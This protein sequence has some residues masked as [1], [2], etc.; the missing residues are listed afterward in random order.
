MTGGVS[1][2]AVPQQVL[3]YEPVHFGWVRDRR[4]VARIAD[5]AVPSVR[6][7]LG[8]EAGYG[9]RWRW[10]TRAAQD[11]RRH[12]NACVGRQRRL[13]FNQT[14]EVMRNVDGQTAQ[15]APSCVGQ[16]FPA[17]RSAPVID[18]RLHAAGVVSADD[19]TID[20]LRDGTDFVE[21]MRISFLGIFRMWKA[22]LNER[23]RTQALGVAQSEPERDTTSVGMP[24]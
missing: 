7:R 10:R 23:Q 22:R 9:A 21:Q 11:Q 4:H 15:T 20:G 19:A 12:V 13:L 3:H 16:T 1:R 6:K 14:P 18:E 24:D 2:G 17:A 8:K 5:R